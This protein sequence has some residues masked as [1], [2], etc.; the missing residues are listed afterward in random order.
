MAKLY[1]ADG[2]NAIVYN[3][4]TMTHEPLH[5]GRAFDSDDPFVKDIAWAFE[6]PVEQATAAPG[7]KRN[8]TRRSA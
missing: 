6:A 4:H 8:T 5:A 1:V 7:E 2:V 3:H